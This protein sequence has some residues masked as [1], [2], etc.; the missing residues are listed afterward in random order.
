MFKVFGD[1]AGGG[2][3]GDDIEHDAGGSRRD[4][5]QG[6][7]GGSSAEQRSLVDVFQGVRP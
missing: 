5:V 3:G 6:E 4:V 7:T 1:E 2:V